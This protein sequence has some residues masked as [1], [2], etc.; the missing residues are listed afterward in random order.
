MMKTMEKNNNKI[1]E[2]YPR[3]FSDCEEKG[4]ETKKRK[5]INK[6]HKARRKNKRQYTIENTNQKFIKKT[7]H[8]TKC[9]LT[10]QIYYQRG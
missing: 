7:S 4:R 5:S 6:R 9:Q 2:S 3:L 1:S 8:I 10:R